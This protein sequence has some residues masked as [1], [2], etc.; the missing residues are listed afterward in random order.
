MKIPIVIP[1]YKPDQK[2]YVRVREMLKKQTMK[3]EVLEITGFTEAGGMNHGIKKA[4]GDIVITMNQDCIPEDE[5]WLERLLKPL[6]DKNVVASVSDTIVMPYKLWK[7]ADPIS[8][9]LSIKE[10]KPVRSALDARGCAYRKSVII[11]AG[12]FNENPNFGA[13]GGI[14]DDI[15]MKMKARGKIA[16]P[17]CKIYHWH[18]FTGGERLYLEYKYAQGSGAMVKYFG[19]RMPGCWKRIVKA[20]PLIGFVGIWAVFPVKRAPLLFIL[21]LI[22]SPMIHGMYLAGFWKGFFKMKKE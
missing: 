2:V 16:Y 22:L 13:L 21:Y 18:P 5:H 8:R 20:T 4:K 19:S 17:G 3:N 6:E 7:K 14:D 9:A 11:K 15:Y 10:Q 1:V 12:L